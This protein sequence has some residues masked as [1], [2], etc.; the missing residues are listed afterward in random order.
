MQRIGQHRQ[1][2]ARGQLDPH[3]PA[4]HIVGA[5]DQL[6]RVVLRLAER[7]LPARD[8]A[9]VG[10]LVIK[11]DDQPVRL[12]RGHG[13]VHHLEERLR[14]V[15]LAQALARVDEEA[16]HALPRHLRHLPADFVGRQAVVPEPEGVEA[17][18]EG[19]WS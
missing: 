5:L 19:V 1:H 17:G 13:D 12:G 3:R 2:L 10:V 4:R 15:G 14:E 9:G 18:G 8:A 6:G 11:M 7:H 16:T